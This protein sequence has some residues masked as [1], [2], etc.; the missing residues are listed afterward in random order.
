MAEELVDVGAS[1]PFLIE[2]PKKQPKSK[3]WKGMKPIH[4]NLPQLPFLACIA[5]PRHGGKTVLLYNLLEKRA[6]CYGDA[7]KPS[8]IILFSPTYTFDD[9]LHPLKIQNVYSPPTTLDWVVGHVKQ[10]QKKHMD[11]DNMSGVLLVLEDITSIKGAWKVL[12]D[13]GYTGRHFQIH[14]LAVAHKMSSILRGVRTQLQQWMLFKPHEESEREWILTMFSRKRT[15]EVWENA[16]RRAWDIEYNFLYI[17]FE[18]KGIENIYR[19]GFNEPLFTPEEMGFI[20][21][22]GPVFKPDSPEFYKEHGKEHVSNLKK[23]V[24]QDT[25][26]GDEKKQVIEPPAKRKR[27]RPKKNK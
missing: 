17:D 25:D 16:M 19:S 1:P 26:S 18:R 11:S 27:G 9:T 14:V 23:Q 22:A 24:M 20:E 6:L 4:P 10:Q 12:E 15:W 2:P 8:N 3:N 5:G 7:F 21:S 13:L